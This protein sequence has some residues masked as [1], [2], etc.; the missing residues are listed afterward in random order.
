MRPQDD[1]CITADPAQNVCMRTHPVNLRSNPSMK[2]VVCQAEFGKGF[3]KGFGRSVSGRSHLI[4][5]AG[6]DSYWRDRKSSLC[7]SWCFCFSVKSASTGVSDSS[8][9]SS[10]QTKFKE[11]AVT[12]HAA[13]W[14]I[15]AGW[16][17]GAEWQI[18]YFLQTHHFG[19]SHGSFSLQS[20]P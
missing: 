13:F 8:S 4:C 18:W 15:K 5:V 10:T 3:Q 16:I 12:T 9:V 17:E 1:A 14:D 6:R 20:Q 11:S 2:F 7:F 19:P